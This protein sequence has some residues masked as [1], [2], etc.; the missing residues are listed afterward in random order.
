MAVGLSPRISDRFSE[1]WGLWG[2]GGGGGGGAGGGGKPRRRKKREKRI[3]PELA[4]ITAMHAIKFDKFESLVPMTGAV[5]PRMSDHMIERWS[6]QVDDEGR[7][8][9]PPLRVCSFGER[10]AEAFVAMGPEWRR[11]NLGVISRV[12]PRGDRVS[13]SNIEVLLACKLWEC[14]VQIAS[15]S[16]AGLVDADQSCPL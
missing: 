7:A 9:R 4:A 2:G 11:H 15:T 1:G 13:S 5:K 12:Y 14:G 8:V 16:D 6:R 3:D 10:K